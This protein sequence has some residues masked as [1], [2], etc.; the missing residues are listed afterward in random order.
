M[1]RK[2]SN[3]DAGDVATMRPRSSIREKEI[4]GSPKGLRAYVCA[5]HP[6]TAPSC[7]ATANVAKKRRRDRYETRFPNE[8]GIL[9]IDIAKTGFQV[10]ANASEGDAPSNQKFQ[11]TV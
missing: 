6:G 8:A 9:A 5:Y 4:R 11:L 3:V 7:A 2:G 1:T 10:C